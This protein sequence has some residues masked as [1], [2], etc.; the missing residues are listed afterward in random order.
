MSGG[1]TTA[2]G[3]RGWP[4]LASLV[5]ASTAWACMSATDV[6]ILEIAGSGTMRGRVVLDLDG[7]AAV[8]AADEPLIDTEIVLVSSSTTNVI[9][10]TTTDVEGAF[11][12][13]DVPVGSYRVTLDAS[14]L[15]DSLSTFGV[16]D[17][18]TVG[19]GDTVEVVFG[20]T[21]PSLGLAEVLTASPGSRVFTTGV[22]LNSR[23]NFGDGQVHFRGAGAYL[24]GLNVERGTLA[25]GDSVRILGHVVSD[26]G[27]PA[28]QDVT[29][30]T[31]V[32]QAQ[33]I[34]PV[35]VST[36]A[37]A[38]ADGGP[39]DAALVRMRRAEITDTSTTPEGHFRFWADDGTDSVEFVIRDFLV[40]GINTS[41]FRPDTVVRIQQA[42]G[43]LSPWD[44]GSG[45]IRW[46]FLPRAGSDIVLE[47]KLVDVR[48]TGA[49]DVAG[50]ST[51]DT[52]E[53]RVAATNGGPLRAT[54]VQVRDTIPAGAVFVSAATTRGS[55]D[56]VTGLWDLGDLDAGASDTLRIRLEITLAAPGTVT[57]IAQ[58]LPLTREF[59]TNGP[60]DT[61]N[62]G[63]PIS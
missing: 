24:R 9:D 46:R 51:G 41:A 37:A 62:T 50:A 61:A 43:L 42:T 57:N 48:L 20:A 18:I 3:R 53:V 21:F 4:L 33:A 44:D 29:F 26:N 23:V 59:D 1:P 60:N 12:L 45:D 2:P 25:T 31:L 34:T 32:S 10:V 14:V 17:P 16:D 6:E 13:T 30:F 15:G 8:S 54:G 19:V 35:E 38:T 5:L 63:L 58:V 40:P 7:N 52:V 22:A 27:R 11:E 49:F 47:N 36:A 39:L 55:Y 56:D 28:I